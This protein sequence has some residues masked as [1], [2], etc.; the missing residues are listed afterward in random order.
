M[1]RF[2]VPEPRVEGDLIRVTGNEAK[3]I[4]TVLRLKTGDRLSIFD[5][6]SKEYEGTIVKADR[7]D[8]L[9]RIETILRPRE[10]FGLAITLAQSLLKGD[11]MDWVIQKATEL[12][13]SE[14]I[15]FFSSRTVP[16]LEPSKAK[17]RHKRWRRIA[18]E[19]SK[20]C[21]RT[22]LPRVSPLLDYHQVLRVPSRNAL[23]LFL[24][25][26]KGAKLKEVLTGMGE[27][28]NIFVV[29]GPEGG[30]ADQEAEEAIGVGFIPITLG[31]R[32]L[33]AETVG[34][35]VLSILQYELGDMG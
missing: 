7:S 10:A 6:S 11:K 18:V 17:D 23:R 31:R 20:Q 21:G 35:S 14:L 3:H 27:R 24:W 34:L 15:P 19:A 28:E 4:R 26:K 29:V 2:Y 32:T 8:V 16:L 1:P 22:L 25:E 5:G 30:W 13:A 9:V 33:R 12:G